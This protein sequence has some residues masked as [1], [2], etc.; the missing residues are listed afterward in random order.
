MWGKGVRSGAEVDQRVAYLYTLRD[1]DNKIVC[2]QL[3]PSIEDAMTAA[4]AA[5]VTP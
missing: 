5:K 3:M 1:A 2:C 4:Q